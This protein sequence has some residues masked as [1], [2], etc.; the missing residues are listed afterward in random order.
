LTVVSLS[1]LLGGGLERKATAELGGSK[2]YVVIDW[3]NLLLV[4][5]VTTLCCCLGV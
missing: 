5:R 3:G 2:D 4:I 1:T